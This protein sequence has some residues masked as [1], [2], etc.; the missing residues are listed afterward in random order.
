MKKAEFYRHSWHTGSSWWS[1]KKDTVLT[2]GVGLWGGTLITP[3]SEVIATVPSLLEL[4]SLEFKGPWS[5]SISCLHA[6]RIWSSM[7]SKTTHCS[8]TSP[9]T[10]VASS[11]GAE[12][13]LIPYQILQP[14]CHCIGVFSIS[15]NLF[16]WLQQSSRSRR[17]GTTGRRNVLSIRE[18]NGRPRSR[19]RNW[20]WTRRGRNRFGVVNWMHFNGRSVG[21]CVR[22]KPANSLGSLEV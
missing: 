4:F 6:V 13:S 2:A 1:I 15:D 7:T 11:W 22:V 12:G 20:N 3:S 19:R 10:L 8:V 9:L 5:G 14:F 17:V 18:R 16:Y 21:L